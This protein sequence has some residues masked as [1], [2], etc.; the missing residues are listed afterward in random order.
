M[1]W[2][3]A[4]YPRGQPGLPDDQVTA[5]VNSLR[6]TGTAPGSMRTRRVRTTRWHDP[7]RECNVRVASASSNSEPEPAPHHRRPTTGVARRARRGQVLAPRGAD[8]SSLGTRHGPRALRLTT[9]TGHSCARE[10]PRRER[11]AA[12]A[13]PGCRAAAGPCSN[14]AGS[15]TNARQQLARQQGH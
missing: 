1:E 9:C 6:A 7:T 5:Y 8:P 4:L 12:Q 13:P 3:I 10:A 2:Y 14:S 11:R 15:R